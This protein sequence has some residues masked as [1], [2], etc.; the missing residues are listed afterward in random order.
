MVFR[1]KQLALQFR[2][3][4]LCFVTVCHVAQASFVFPMWPGLRSS[5]TPNSAASIIE[6]VSGSS[7][8]S[9]YVSFFV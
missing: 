5:G 7:L 3:C 8:T 2:P 4:E 6:M 9:N 1:L